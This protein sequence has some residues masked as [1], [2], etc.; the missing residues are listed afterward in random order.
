MYVRLV[1]TATPSR[2]VVIGHCI[3]HTTRTTRT[4]RTA[5]PS[6]ALA[7]PRVSPATSAAPVSSTAASAASSALEGVDRP[8]PT[9]SHPRRLSRRGDEYRVVVPAV[10]SVPAAVPIPLTAT[11]AAP[12]PA[13][14]GPTAI[15]RA[16]NVRPPSGFDLPVAAA[17][18]R[19]VPPPNGVAIATAGRSVRPL[20]LVCLLLL[21]LRAPASIGGGR[22]VA[23]VKGRE[24]AQT[25]L[26]LQSVAEVS[27]TPT[28]KQFR[29][30]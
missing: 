2:R 19:G 23:L 5:R 12:R 10:R 28:R 25:V 6:P 18:A 22:G 17:A 11:T 24:H 21:L 4:T 9:P 26:L 27:Q 15:P 30:S 29:W 8:A 1:A 13:V 16:S 7:R 20:R 14:A 3:V